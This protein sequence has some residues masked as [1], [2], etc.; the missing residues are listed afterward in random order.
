MKRPSCYCPV[1][2]T[3]LIL[4]SRDE[5]TLYVILFVGRSECLSVCVGLLCFF[6]L[7]G[8][9]G[10]TYVVHTAL[11]LS[12]FSLNSLCSSCFLPVPVL[13]AVEGDK[14]L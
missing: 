8:I 2:V 3:V 10:A 7:F 6:K 4:F 9:Q 11:L 14:V 5:A 13:L 1:P 12:E